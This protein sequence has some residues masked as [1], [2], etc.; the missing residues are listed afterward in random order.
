MSGTYA[1]MNHDQDSLK[2]A[3]EGIEE[4]YLS[5]VNLIQSDGRGG[6]MAEEEF[7]IDPNDP[8]W[9]AMY[10]GQK[11]W[12]TKTPEQWAKEAKENQGQDHPMAPEVEF[13]QSG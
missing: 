3:L 8:F 1:N 11:K 10:R 5:R 4:D 12:D 9:K 6:A 2:K 7:Q 13:D